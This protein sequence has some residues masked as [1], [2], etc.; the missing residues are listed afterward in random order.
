MTTSKAASLGFLILL[1]GLGGCGSGSSLPPK[2]VRDSIAI[3]PTSAPAGIS[4]LT[5]T[6]TGS[7]F[8]GEPHNRSVAA[9]STNGSNTF[10][11]T[12]F[13]SGTQLT[14]VIPAALLSSPI[15]ATVFVETGDPMGDVFLKSDSVAFIVTTLAPGSPLI[16]SISPTNAE[17]GSPD[18]AL[19]VTGSNFAN[20]NNYHSYAN[21]SV[22]GN[23]TFLATTF[24]SDTQLTAIIPAALL[25]SPITA[26]ISVQIFYKA[27]DDPSS[28][29]NSVVFSINA[30]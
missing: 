24:V 22:N 26:E 18:L 16:S 3:S 11:A 13:V 15:T 10:L 1:I 9:W 30:P 6:V 2:Q 17:A 20:E 14:A 29:S 7:H 8:A 4:D 21:W 5:L 28:Q 25:I 19:T 23:Q 27:N 12:T